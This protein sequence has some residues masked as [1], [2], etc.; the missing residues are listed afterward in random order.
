MRLST[1]DGGL[2]MLRSQIPCCNTLHS[3]HGQ[4]SLH[5]QYTG[6]IASWVTVA[7][8]A[9]VAEEEEPE[10]DSSDSEYSGSRQQRAAARRARMRRAKARTA[11]MQMPEDIS[12]DEEAARENAAPE[13]ILLERPGGLPP[14]IMPSAALGAWL[15]LH[16]VGK[17]CRIIL[18]CPTALVVGACPAVRKLSPRLSSLASESRTSETFA[19]DMLVHS[20]TSGP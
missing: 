10:P 18:R 8:Q 13:S 17:E 16:W 1:V 20:S 4:Q 6:K 5:F 14:V 12:S 19:C 11:A 2:L 9:G 7:P 15:L 3:D